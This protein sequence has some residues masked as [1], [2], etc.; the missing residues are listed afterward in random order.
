MKTKKALKWVGI[1]LLSPILLFLLLTILLYIPPIQNWAVKKL[2]AYASEQTGMQITIQHVDIGFPLDIG[3]DG[4]LVV[5]G[6]DTIADIGRLVAD[7]KFWPLLESKVE[8][9]RLE[10][11]KTKIN[12]NKFIEDM[13]V[14]G[15]FDQLAFESRYLD[16]DA[17]VFQMNNARLKNADLTIMLS[18]TA[19]VD[20]TEVIQWK[21]M[22]DRLDIDR[23]Q[24]TILMDSAANFQKPTTTIIAA[25]GKAKADDGLI[26]LAVS[27]YDIGHLDWDDGQV[28]YDS[29]FALHD[30]HL[31]IDRLHSQSPITS[32]DL[33]E[34]RLKEQ[35]TGIEITE[36]K[37][38]VTLDATGIRLTDFSLATPYSSAQVKADVD[39][40]ALDDSIDNPGRMDVAL[41]ASLGK[42]DL[43]RFM[44]DM[45]A[46]FKELWPSKPLKIKGALKGNVKE[47]EIPMLSIELPDAF[48]AEASGTVSNLMD[49]DRLLAQLNWKMQLTGL[50]FL[51]PLIPE[52]GRSFNIPKGLSMEGTVNADGPRYFADVTMRDGRGRAHI[53]GT[54]NQQ[55]MAY[56]A[57]VKVNQL[58]LHRYLPQMDL[59]SLTAQAKV[60]GKGTD[61]LK[62]SSWLEADATINHLRYGNTD[63]ENITAV[64]RLNDGHAIATLTGDNKL[65]AGNLSVDALLNT[66]DLKATIASDV[67]ELDLYALGLTDHPLTVGLCGDLKVASDM[68]QTHS[69]SGLVSELYLRDSLKT[70]R[71]ENLGILL[72]TSPDTTYARMQSGSLIVKMDA[73]GG[74]E[75]LF[76]RFSLLADSVKAQ[77]ARHTIDQTQLRTMLPTM[78]LYM[79]SGRNNPMA[80]ILRASSNIDFKDMVVDL[81]TS[82]E[83]GLNGN[84]HIY[85]LNVDSTR[86]DTVKITFKD[87]PKGLSYQA[88]VTNNKRNPQ[89]V[90][91]AL[92]DGRVYDRGASVGLRFYDAA[93]KMGVRIGAY[94]AVEDDGI[95]FRLV[96]ERPTLGY[97]EFTLNKDNFLFIRDDVKLQAHIDLIADDGTGVKIYSEEQNPD[98]LQDLTIS[99]NRFDLGNLTEVLPYFPKIGG[100][101]NGDYHLMMNEQRQISVASDMEV[102]SMAYEGC[103][104]G[105][106]STEFV[107]LLRDDDTHAVEGILLRNGHEI[108]ALRGEYR[109]EGAG[110][111]DA[112]LKLT[113]TPMMLINGFIPDQLFGF[114]GYAE[115][116]VAVKGSLRRP[117]VEGEVYLDSA[118]L[119]SQ[120]YGIRLRFDNDPV[121]IIGSKLLLEN[122]TMYAH[123]D[124]PLNI[125]GQIDFSDT[126]HMS[127]DV[128]MR[129]QNFQLINSKQTSKSIAYGKMFVN[130]FATMNGPM[131][132]LKMRGK[133]DILGSTDLRYILLDSPLSTDNQLEELVKF[134]DFTDTTQA[135]VDRPVPE[136]LDMDLN[137][138]IDQGAHARC[139]LNVDQTNYVDLLGGGD[140]R[141]RYNNDGLALTGRYTINS[142]EM[143]YSLPVIPLKTF[144]IQEGS[145]VE[146]TGDVGNPTLNL[147]ATER[148]RASV[149]Q[150][151]SQTRSVAFDCGV[152]ITRTLNDMGLEFIISAPED[153][154]V[155]NELLSMGPEQRGKLA[156]T[157]LT[158]GM[159]LADGNTGGFSMN[160]ALSSFLQSEI[161]TITGNAL[162]TLDLSIGLDNTT[163]ASGQMHTDYSFKFAKRFWNN[164]LKVQLGGKV[165][166][167]QEIQGQNQSFFDNVTME[168]RL[169]PTANQYVKLFYNQNA[170]DWLEGYTG[171]Y[172]GG[173]VWR[174]KL[175]KFMDIFRISGSSNNNEQMPNNR[176]K[177]ESDTIIINN[178]ND[179]QKD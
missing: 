11:N 71:P 120:P 58:D 86:I 104:M 95:R 81:T 64:A 156:V 69:V 48:A 170:Y 65:L 106:I 103:E 178:K 90:F 117:D 57:D 28:S 146:F 7:V 129:A 34:A 131:D 56:D 75:P 91:N 9:G 177:E 42:A 73:S 80:D 159:Y 169:S 97:K 101:L 37:G 160:S 27:R 130:F 165:S 20:T 126:D 41:D 153:M 175:D 84:A 127:M 98:L 141:M 136:G 171:E 44:D 94:A 168:Y 132:R 172:G 55:T 43:M 2:A 112:N 119:V 87:S 83:K 139:D 164:R 137:I 105:D 16:L 1:A 8:L 92:L 39:Y 35:Y 52:L 134:T 24:F 15:Q 78:R 49:T 115:G 17:E 145:Y 162:K 135:V 138:G 68:K 99:L 118:Y 62:K 155:N 21:I 29:L 110:Y 76:D 93:G 50:R 142:G 125:M 53:K 121:R 77:I 151:G 38:P 157:M 33:Q 109:N 36:A 14:K 72:K 176:R 154:S 3:A 19:M 152:V 179:E 124:N 128:K 5:Q 59:H 88:Q 67:H 150:A 144:T 30:L 82:P 6:G 133:L 108:G 22:F 4:V 167:G 116:S 85:S 54:L 114:E 46:K 23:S 140:L 26:D 100:M 174:R 45:P 32:L 96:P 143:K 63:I 31:A 102:R 66:D 148:T 61:F 47:A 149:G 111:L 18:D 79:T 12:T 13:G 123:N 10:L 163:D 89:L 51:Q 25:M 113:R 107:Y 60:K 122:F 166:T 173:F 161:N 158:T 74:Y 70:H 147:T 40:T